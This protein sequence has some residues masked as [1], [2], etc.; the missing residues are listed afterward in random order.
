[1]LNNNTDWKAALA[2]AVG[3]SFRAHVPRTFRA[4]VPSQGWPGKEVK[5][6]EAHTACPARDGEFVGRWGDNERSVQ[7]QGRVFAFICGA[8]VPQVGLIE[9]AM[10]Q[11]GLHFGGL[12]LCV[13][14]CAWQVSVFVGM[15]VV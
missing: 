4:R 1:M 5:C 14:A 9:D 15:K 2:L 13:Q 8:A 3:C 12:N 7:Y 11:C 6:R 10:A